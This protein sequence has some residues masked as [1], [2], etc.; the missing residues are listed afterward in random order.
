MYL[1]PLPSFISTIL[2][3]RL[4]FLKKDA[5]KTENNMQ[6]IVEVSTNTLT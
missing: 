5:L 6:H 2:R 4:R 1:K 3:R